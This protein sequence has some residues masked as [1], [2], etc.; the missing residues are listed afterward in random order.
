MEVNVLLF[1]FFYFTHFFPSR[2]TIVDTIN[3]SKTK[4]EQRQAT[5]INISLHRSIVEF[6]VAVYMDL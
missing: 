5:I 3:W 1:I 4:N 6:V 2:Q